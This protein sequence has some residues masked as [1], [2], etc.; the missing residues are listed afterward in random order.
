M[1]PIFT[2]NVI[3]GN[4]VV[5]C[6]HSNYANNNEIS[7]HVT[8]DKTEKRVGFSSD[9]TTYLSVNLFN[10]IFNISSAVFDGKDNYITKK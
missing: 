8:Q 5:F 7:S 9:P 2:L 6:S 10:S 4:L 1:K 3:M